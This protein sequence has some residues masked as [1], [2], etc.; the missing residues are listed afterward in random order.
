[1][2]TSAIAVSEPSSPARGTTSR[3][4]PLTSAQA[5]LKTPEA[6]SIAIPRNQACCAAASGSSPRPVAAWNAG[7]M[8]RKTEPKVLGVSSPSGIAVTSLPAR[9]AG[10]GGTPSP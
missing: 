4:Q 2:I 7:P 1:M 8:I 6:R 3:T 5:S 9:S 10:P